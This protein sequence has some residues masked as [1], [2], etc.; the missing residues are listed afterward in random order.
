[1]KYVYILLTVCLFSSM[2]CDKDG[3]NS[4]IVTVTEQ[5]TFGDKP[6]AC[7]VE[8]PDLSKHG[9]LCSIP[10]GQSKPVYSCADAVYIKNLPA[11]LAVP[12]KRII[13]YG[14]SDAGQPALFSSINHAHELTVSNAQEAR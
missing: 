1:M 13:F 6:W 9:F 7:I 5:S 8:N 10:A 12:G 14:Y 2:K 11:N 4:V 3:S